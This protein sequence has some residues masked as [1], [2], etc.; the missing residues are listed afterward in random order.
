MKNMPGR[1]RVRS[2]AFSTVT[3]AFA[4]IFGLA[5]AVSCKKETPKPAV[6][7]QARK[8][9][10]ARQTAPPPAQAVKE[11][12]GLEVETYAYNS[13]GRRDPFLSIIEASKK[14][15]EAQKRRKGLKPS[16]SYDLSELRVIAI[17]RDKDRYYAM[18]LLPDK[19]YFTVKEGMILGTRGGK[20][21]KI[22]ERGVLVR[23][24]ITNYKGEIQP[25]DTIIRLRNEEG[26]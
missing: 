11:A 22:D 10:A 18:I 25:K 5:F 16:E 14:K 15:T 8:V 9:Q 2:A 7:K 23:E 17:A 4:M 1:S 6:Q 19:K 20:I 24:Y 26:E 13:K 3:L 21:I 12:K